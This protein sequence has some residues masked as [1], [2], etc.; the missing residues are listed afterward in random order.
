ML[1]VDWATD[2][3]AEVGM[4]LSVGQVKAVSAEEVELV[5]SEAEFPWD[6]GPVEGSRGDFLWGFL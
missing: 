6:V 3:S 4:G 5:D 1:V 2:F